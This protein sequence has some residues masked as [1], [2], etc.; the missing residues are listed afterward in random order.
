MTD[1]LLLDLLPAP[2][3]RRLLALCSPLPLVAGVHLAVQD[4]TTRELLF[5]VSGSLVLLAAIPEHPLLQ[6]GMLGQEGCLGAQPEV[7]CHHPLG[8]LVL[9]AGLAWRVSALTLRRQLPQSPAPFPSLLRLLARYRHVQLRQLATA[10]TCLHF[11][12]LAM[13]LA[14]WLLMALDRSDGDRYAVTHEQMAG[15]LG[16]RR[17]G[18]TVAAGA[19]Q[20]AGLIGYHRGHVQVHDRDGLRAAACSCYAQDLASY[21]LGMGLRAA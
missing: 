7:A 9:G 18:V 12:P 4:E 1:N 16:A 2:E 5:P 17:V 19:L 6:V 15:W 20:A 3:R 21:R 10:A 14:R 13:R 11:H 8:A